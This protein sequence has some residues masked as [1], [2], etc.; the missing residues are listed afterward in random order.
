MVPFLLF[1]AVIGRAQ[2]PSPIP[3]FAEG[4]KQLAALGMPPLDAKATW[5]VVSEA[6][7]PSNYQ[8]REI[9]KSLK[10]NAWLLP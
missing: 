7:N 4:F 9:T 2:Q 6:A 1:S 3:D 5:S 8:L 10:G